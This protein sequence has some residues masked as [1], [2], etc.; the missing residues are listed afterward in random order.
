SDDLDTLRAAL[1]TPTLTVLAHGYAA[2]IA[3]VYADRFPGR[4]A[5]MVLD[6]P[7]DPL[8]GPVAEAKASATA[9]ET[10][11]AQFAAACDGFPKGCPLG[12]DPVAAVTGIVHKLA[13]S[14]EAAGDWVMTGGSVLLALLT[15]LPDRNSWP[16]LA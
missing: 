5:A 10:V 16:E 7:T 8:S 6:S 15:M 3:A 9:A 13:T 12:D 11:L 14:G 1:G 2:T 4:V